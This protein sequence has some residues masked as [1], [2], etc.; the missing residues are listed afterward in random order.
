MIAL[1]AV[2]AIN[3]A[4]LTISKIGCNTFIRSRVH[5]VFV[6]SGIAHLASYGIGANGTVGESRS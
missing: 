4:G 2:G 3:T 6:N 1:S 5:A